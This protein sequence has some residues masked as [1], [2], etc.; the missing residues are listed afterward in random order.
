MC[1]INM[2]VMSGLEFLQQVKDDK[3]APGVP[4]VMV[5]TEG[6]EP[7]VRQAILVGARGYIR[8]PFTL[9]HIKNSVAPLLAM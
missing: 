7:Q 5:T 6:S 8:K 4:I 2:P 3:L 1:D 9:E